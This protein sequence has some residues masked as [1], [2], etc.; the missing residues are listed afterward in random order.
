MIEDKEQAS[1]IEQ[2]TLAFSLYALIFGLFANIVYGLY[3]KSDAIILNGILFLLYFISAILGLLAAKLVARPADKVF[4]YG[5]WHVE[6]MVNCFNGI[7]MVMVCFY[8]LLNGIEGIRHGGHKVDTGGATWFSGLSVVFCLL[9]LLY[10]KWACRQVN[11]KLL[12]NDTGKWVIKTAF[13]TVTF[14]GFLF[15]YF[16]GDAYSDSWVRYMDSFMVVV[17]ALFLLPT[18]LRVII[19]N[20]KELLHMSTVDPLLLE[21]LNQVIKQIQTDYAIKK[22]TSHVTQ[23]GRLNLLEINFLVDGQSELQNIKNQD[24][25]RSRIWDFVDS[26]ATEIWLSVCFTADERWG[27]F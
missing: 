20:M 9:I 22:H 18:P 5:Y 3:I 24:E 27:D 2:R 16:L 4:Q 13:S 12:R 1:I 25:L 14:I 11:S 19:G 8:A 26:P 15:T 7:L 17:L 6:P 21:R 23:V 10:K